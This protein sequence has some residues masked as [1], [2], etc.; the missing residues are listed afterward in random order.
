MSKSEL[1]RIGVTLRFT[2]DVAVSDVAV[3]VPLAKR[4]SFSNAATSSGVSVEIS[5]PTPVGLELTLRP[6]VSPTMGPVAP[7]PCVI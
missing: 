1:V 7:V 2:P 5:L 6:E 3:E 4:D